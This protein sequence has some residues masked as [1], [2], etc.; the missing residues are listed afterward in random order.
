MKDKPL[1]T[2]AIPKRRYQ[3]GDYSA[4]LLGEIASGDERVFRYILAFVAMGQR[5]PSL[6]VCSEQSP[7]AES[8]RG[9][10]RLRLINEAM[11]EIM[12]QD[13]RWGELDAFAEQ[14]VQLGM[15]ALGLHGA[16]VMRLL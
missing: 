6:Y 1:I 15:Q 16:Q 3:I 4:S 2:T 8:D 5:E 10:Y 7:P 9:R 13:D 11:S 14:A 12:E